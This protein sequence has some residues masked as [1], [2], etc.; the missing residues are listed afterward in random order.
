MDVCAKRCLYS[1][2]TACRFSIASGAFTCTTPISELCDVSWGLP[3]KKNCHCTLCDEF[4]GGYIITD[5]EQDD[6]TMEFQLSTEFAMKSTRKWSKIQG[7]EVIGRF[8][9]LKRKPSRHHSHAP[10]PALTDSWASGS[11]ARVMMGCSVRWWQFSP[12][13]HWNP[14]WFASELKSL[15]PMYPLLNISMENGHRDS[16]FFHWKWGFSIVVSNYQRVHDSTP[17]PLLSQQLLIRR[18]GEPCWK[19]L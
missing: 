10:P 18:L 15:S 14:L 12:V 7:N 3:G 13:N 4:M 8:D 16:G 6:E 1:T 9:L 2:Y 5:G 19:A 17:E 11:R